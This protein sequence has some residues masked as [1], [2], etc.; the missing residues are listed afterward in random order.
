MSELE[1]LGYRWAH[2][3][4]GLTGFGL[5]QRRRRVFILASLHGDPRDVLLAPQSV[6]M[7]QCLDLNRQGVIRRARSGAG[8]DADDDKTD[9]PPACT[10]CII[11][12]HANS[13]DKPN[14]TVVE[15]AC[16]HAAREC[17]TCFMTP[18]FVEPRRTV[19]CVDL[20]EK[21]HGPML[22]ELFTLTTANGKRMCIVEDMVERPMKA[23]E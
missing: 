19:A 6:C 12:G 16:H 18:P 8:E 22:H 20:A 13:H 21:R 5:P 9:P 10:E 15:T 1:S 7:G 17:Y 14:R 11:T 23:C 3:V 2:R 4:I